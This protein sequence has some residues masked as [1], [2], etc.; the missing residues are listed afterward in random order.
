MR[1]L[2]KAGILFSL[3]SCV[4]LADV[5]RAPL[6]APRDKGAEIP[7]GAT[8]PIFPDWSTQPPPSSGGAPQAAP[9][10]N[11]A[12]PRPKAERL[13]PRSRL[14]IIRYVM[15]EFARARRPIPGGKSGF[16]YAPLQQPKEE[17]LRRAYAAGG[18]AAHPG[19]N[20]QITSIEFR[21]REIRVDINGGGKPKRNWRDR[22]QI[23]TGGIPTVTTST[24]GGPPGLQGAGSTLILD[25]GQPLPDLSP[26][27]LKQHLSLFLD[28][29]K[30]RS[31]AVDWVSTL[32]P[33][34]QQAIKERRAAV[35]MDKEMVIAAMGRPERKIR[36]RRE[37][38]GVETEDWIYGHPPA[39]TVFV[40]FANE[41]V[42]SVKEYPR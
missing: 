6:L 25:Y 31:A 29:S 38:D 16:R 9:G 22:I 13:Q 2:A 28:F 34:F 30:Q 14:E 41:K 27:D 36:E 8:I 10:K 37:E 23:S 15:G 3:A 17:E 32:S 5:P 20:V 7:H 33:E 42:I 39:K 24:S 19:D 21:D 26:D 11:A 4:A 35:G 18:T 40:T 12:E 1:A